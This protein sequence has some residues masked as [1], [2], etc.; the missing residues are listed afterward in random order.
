MRNFS[1]ICSLSSEE[2]KKGDEVQLFFIASDRI[3]NGKL[4]G[5]LKGE[6]QN[7]YDGFK[8]I[9]GF[10]LSAVY[11]GSGA[12]KITDKETIK[13]DYIKN[14]IKERCLLDIKSNLHEM[15][16]F[17]KELND[18]NFLHAIQGNINN[19]NVYIKHYFSHDMMNFVSLMAI[20][21]SVYNEFISGYKNY[22]DHRRDYHYFSTF[23]DNIEKMKHDFKVWEEERENKI[24][25]FVEK[26]DN[27]ISEAKVLTYSTHSF[28]SK[29]QVSFIYDS[30]NVFKKL[31]YTGQYNIDRLFE[32]V[33]E[34]MFFAGKMAESYK[35]F[36]PNMT[37]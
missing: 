30:E 34:G 25:Y 12:Y 19:G 10:G 35:L 18:L 7:P 21:K 29:I 33:E 16:I 26:N 6:V 32:I 8:L 24:K 20:K 1:K 37:K 22:Y 27:L 4:Q 2:I 9:G 23:S 15:N 17:Y 5:I 14:F 28:Y 13:T 11:D 3:K 31:Y 36:L